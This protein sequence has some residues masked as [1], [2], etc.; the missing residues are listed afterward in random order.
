MRTRPPIGLLSCRLMKK[1]FRPSERSIFDIPFGES[2]ALLGAGE[3]NAGSLISL[4]LLLRCD[5]RSCC[6]VLDGL[7]AL[8]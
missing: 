8:M 6:G 1:T 2:T 5:A 7:A 3:A 4:P